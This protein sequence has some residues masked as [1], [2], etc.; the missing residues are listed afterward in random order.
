LACSPNPFRPAASA[1]RAV[2]D[3]RLLEGLLIGKE[4]RLHAADHEERVI[5][6]RTGWLIEVVILALFEMSPD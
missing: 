6:A 1:S 3:E 4:P 2:P 5:F